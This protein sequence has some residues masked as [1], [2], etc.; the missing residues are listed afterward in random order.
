MLICVGARAAPSYAQ[1][2]RTICSLKTFGVFHQIPQG[3]KSGGR[4]TPPPLLSRVADTN[5]AIFSSAIRQFLGIPWGIPTE[6][7]DSTWYLGVGGLV[8]PGPREK[9]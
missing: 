9:Q 1:A 8:G 4:G 5:S 3:G 7:V 2:A 6:V